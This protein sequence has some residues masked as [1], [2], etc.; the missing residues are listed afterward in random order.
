MKTSELIAGR[1]L[2][3]RLTARP[4]SKWIAGLLFLA[5]A[6][7][8]EPQTA[9]S[10]AQQQVAG[11]GPARPQRPQLPAEVEN[12]KR[13]RQQRRRSRDLQTMLGQ[14]AQFEAAPERMSLA[15]CAHW[16]HLKAR[17][18]EA[19]GQERQVRA[20]EAPTLEHCDRLHQLIGEAKR[21]VGDLRELVLYGDH[22][23]GLM[24]RLLDE[25]LAL[26]SATSGP[27]GDEQLARELDK[28]LAADERFRL[29]T[30]H[31]EQFV[32]LLRQRLAPVSRKEEEE[33]EA[34][35]D[36]IE[37]LDRVLKRMVDREAELGE[38]EVAQLDE[39]ANILEQ[40]L[41]EGH[42][43]LR[44]GR[45]QYLS[46][47]LDA[48]RSVL[49]RKLGQR[50]SM[51]PDVVH[52]EHPKEA[53]EAHEEEEEG[54]EEGEEEE[55]EGEEEEDQQLR[56][57]QLATAEAQAVAYADQVANQFAEAHLEA[58]VVQQA[59]AEPKTPRAVA[60]TAASAGPRFAS[61]PA[62]YRELDSARA[63]DRIQNGQRRPVGQTAQRRQQQVAGR[64]A[65]A[66]LRAKPSFS[67][68]QRRFAD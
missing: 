23:L 17:Y 34:E 67:L 63:A 2:A 52:Y 44:S 39:L 57:Q 8:L 62:N 66:A 64:P 50:K 58:P 30:E 20:G 42:I 28:Q 49:L 22:Q 59:V 21:R 16:A 18:I 35:G 11:R 19:A 48:A 12:V 38:Q 40:L 65:L 4:G 14:L 45:F 43:E 68:R 3:D 37:E 54:E 56:Q 6:L 47:T 33:E 51:P 26:R 55:E 1:R 13:W 60:T 5:L 7:L 10:L 32:D 31:L 41:V 53:H 24:S 61:T 36:E 25:F 46:G 29:G 27:A 15:E 9:D